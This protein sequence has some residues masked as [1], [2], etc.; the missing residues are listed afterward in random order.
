[1]PELPPVNNHEMRRADAPLADG[2]RRLRADLLGA[3]LL[4]AGLLDAGQLGAD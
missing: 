4:G 2:A 1:V 3:D